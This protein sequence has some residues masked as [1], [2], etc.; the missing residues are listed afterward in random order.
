MQ[1]S[2]EER[3]G[4]KVRKMDEAQKSR[5]AALDESLRQVHSS[6]LDITVSIRRLEDKMDKGFE[7]KHA[8]G[9]GHQ[10]TS[11]QQKTSLAAGD[12]QCLPTETIFRHG[13]S[14][15]SGV[16]SETAFEKN[17]RGATHS[18]QKLEKLVI[19]QS[20]VVTGK[21]DIQNEK[22]GLEAGEILHSAEFYREL[23]SS[24]LDTETGVKVELEGTIGLS[25]LGTKLAA[26]DNKLEKILAS[27][28][29]R[30]GADMGDDR[31]D[32]KRLKEK[33]KL[34][35]ELDKQ[36]HVT[37]RNIVSNRELWMEY[38]FGICSP[39]PRTGKRG[40]R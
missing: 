34:A 24:D 32:R 30:S 2:F 15:R 12:K 16:D 31:E 36:S 37:V 29:I 6:L 19:S 1:R 40:S 11:L 13:S 22:I 17:I 25:Q 4:E 14:G 26:M 28:G 23:Q 38:I 20:K 27:T 33:L 18:Q 5:S 10:Y 21:T 9:P 3:L 35:I 8:S 39:E 7:K